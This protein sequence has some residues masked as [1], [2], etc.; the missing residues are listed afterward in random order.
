MPTDIELATVTAN[1]GAGNAWSG[2]PGFPVTASVGGTNKLLVITGFGFTIPG[3]S[4]IN[5]IEIDFDCSLTGAYI[6][7]DDPVFVSAQLYNSGVIGTAKTINQAWTTTNIVLGNSLD[8][9]GA[10]L[11]TAIVNDA[12]F[13]VAVA[14]TFPSTASPGAAAGFTSVTMT[15]TYTTGGGGSG[16][17]GPLTGPLVQTRVLTGMVIR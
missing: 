3:G 11:T 12:N 16:G 14:S 4:T 1:S 6:A 2:T 10:M 8:T 13:G 5:G 9:W 7:L 15:L 17:V